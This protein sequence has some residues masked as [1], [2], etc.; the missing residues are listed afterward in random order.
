MDASFFENK[1][2][3]SQINIMYACVFVCVCVYMNR[4][5]VPFILDHHHHNK[6]VMQI[7]KKKFDILKILFMC[8]C[9]CMAVCSKIKLLPLLLQK[10]LN[11]NNVVVVVDSSQLII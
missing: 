3:E 2:K 10:I 11:P 9:V 1:I 7:Q 6:M 8:V 4:Y 5:S